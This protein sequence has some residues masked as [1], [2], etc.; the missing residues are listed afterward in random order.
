LASEYAP[1]VEREIG[2]PTGIIGRTIEVSESASCV[3]REVTLPIDIVGKV[4]AAIS[5]DVI[6]ISEVLSSYIPI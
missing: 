2:L 3:Q 5:E 6:V 1:R 4:T